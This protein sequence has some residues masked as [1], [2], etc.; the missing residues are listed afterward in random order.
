VIT[1][2]EERERE[3]GEKERVSERER[4]IARIFFAFLESLERASPPPRREESSAASTA[5]RS[6]AALTPPSP[7]C[8]PF[9]GIALTR[10][11]ASALWAQTRADDI[12]RGEVWEER[13]PE[14]SLERV[15][16]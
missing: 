12:Y 4:E 5:V 6:N 8:D 16:K 11:R 2:G 10:E 9:P 7:F 14:R 13:S 1:R 15:I 3:R